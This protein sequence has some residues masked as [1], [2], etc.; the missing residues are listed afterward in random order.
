M[1]ILYKSVTA[2]IQVSTQECWL[3]GVELSNSGNASMIVYDEADDG[4]TAAKKVVNMK[5]SS[6]NRNNSII[7]PDEGVQCDGIYVT[8]SAG[9]VTI[10]YH[11]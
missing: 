6:Y 7:F 4:E 9:I 2:A 1:E 3:V 8:L 11:Y 10:Y 5:C